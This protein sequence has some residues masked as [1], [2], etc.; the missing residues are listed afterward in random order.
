MNATSMEE[1]MKIRADLE[2]RTAEI[3]ADF[4]KIE[5][6]IYNQME[7]IYPEEENKRGQVIELFPSKKEQ[8]KLDD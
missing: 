4:N 1:A 6:E 8:K 3:N 7:L 2:S 5:K